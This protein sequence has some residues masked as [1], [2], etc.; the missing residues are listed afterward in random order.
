MRT[1]ILLRSSGKCRRGRRAPGGR[2]RPGRH[3][4]RLVHVVPLLALL[5]A[6]APVTAGAQAT[7]APS[8]PARVADR[9]LAQRVER[10]FDV[11]P[12]QN[13]IVLTPKTAHG[14][15]RTIELTG[16]TVAINGEAVTGSEL[17]ARLGADAELV[18][19]LTYLTT[20]DQRA[21]FGLAAAGTSGETPAVPPA[22]PVP[23]A[24]EP[25]APAAPAAPPAPE[26]PSSSD[27]M[28]RSSD[29]V[30]IGGS[31]TVN[32]DE[33]VDGDVV[34]VGGSAHINGEVRGDVAVIGGTCRIGPTADIHG[35]VTIMG[36]TLDRNPNAHISGKVNIVGFDHNFL[37]ISPFHR[38]WM[39]V[40]A[41]GVFAFAGFLATTV[42]IALL[43]LLACLVLL[44]VPK[45]V[46]QVA[47]RV[48]TEPVKAWLIG[49]ACEL[50]FLPVLILTI[51][52]L[53]V[54]IIGIPLL[55]LVPFALI[56][57]LLI[58]LLGYTA[59]AV[60]IGHFIDTRLGWR[61]EGPYLP[62]IVGVFTL[63]ALSIFGRLM[64]MFGGIFDIF[65]LF[66][67]V[68]ALIEWTAWTTGFGAC[69]LVR[70]GHR[71]PMAA[72]T[73]GGQPPASAPAADQP[74]A[75]PPAGPS[76]I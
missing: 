55:V 43:I 27:R 6:G 34:V 24:A 31:L 64:G 30:R 46:E 7:S 58:G 28:H 62:A 20:A 17:N 52:L 69:V 70:F 53:V 59:V 47:A 49:L 56:A 29:R 42:R 21:L 44:I 61:L 73:G 22:P 18:L 72:M 2:G 33:I 51:I 23:P 14:G 60:Q 9:A 38:N 35:D 71:L 4:W 12:V 63:G 36:G 45:P 41:L 25:A 54:T 40:P 1:P 32:A 13:G 65:G 57:L 3:G 76:G 66:A 8:A 50:L 10:R 5:V 16:G 26:E 37:P 19:P 11:L 68:G 74:P 75:A 15:I 48:S 39:F 67:L